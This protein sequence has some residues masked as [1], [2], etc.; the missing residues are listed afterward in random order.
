MVTSQ[1]L[2]YSVSESALKLEEHFKL[3][4]FSC[5][6]MIISVRAKQLV[7]IN[8]NTQYVVSYN[9]YL[10]YFILNLFVFVNLYTSVAWGQGYQITI[11]I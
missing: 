4:F 11:Q 1:Y 7:V 9:L 3:L 5:F 6:I 8:L 2:Q 10:F